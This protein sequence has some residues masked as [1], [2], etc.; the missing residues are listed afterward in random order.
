M[1]EDILITVVLVTYNAAETIET[2]ILSVLN[3]TYKNIECLV[4]DGASTDNTVD[5]IKKYNIRYISE[6]DKG[7][8]DAMNKGWKQGRGEWVLYLGADDEL[9]SNGI[10]ALVNVSSNAEI[11]YGDTILKF[12]SGNTKRRGI[13]DLSVI[14]YYL[15]SSHQSFMMKKSVIDSLGGF[16]LK[17]KIYGDFDLIQRAYIN[18]YRFRQTKE[19]ISIFFLGGISTNN[20]MAERE[21]YILLKDNKLAKYPLLVCSYFAL[22]K[23]LLK[24]KHLYS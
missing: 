24:I 11:V 6:P 4:I 21:R 15:C 23:I 18:G 14:K 22:K 7:I 8:Y 20:I 16:N 5:I 3:Q 17:Y 13:Q 10:E 19:V 1:R 2:A 9:V 12:L